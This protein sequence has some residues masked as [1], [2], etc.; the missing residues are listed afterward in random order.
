M[1]TIVDKAIDALRS[2]P[3]DRQRELAESVIAAAEDTEELTAAEQA[4]VDEGLAQAK[5]G[6]F[7]SD[8]EVARLFRDLSAA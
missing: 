4:A 3:E 2:L 6:E 8:E 1:T 5:A 7:V